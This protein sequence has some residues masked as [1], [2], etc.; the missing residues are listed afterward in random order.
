[1]EAFYDFMPEKFTREST[2]ERMERMSMAKVMEAHN[3]EEQGVELFASGDVNDRCRRASTD[4]PAAG[5]AGERGSTLDNFQHVR[6]ITSTVRGTRSRSDS[7]SDDSWK[8]GGGGGEGGAFGMSMSSL[9]GGSSGSQ[10]RSDS[11]DEQKDAS[12]K[13]S[14]GS[15]VSRKLKKGAEMGTGA[16]TG[17]S[18]GK[19]SFTPSAGTPSGGLRLSPGEMRRPSLRGVVKRSS[20]PGE[21][22]NKVAGGLVAGGDN[23]IGLESNPVVRASKFPSRRRLSSYKSSSIPSIKQ[24]SP[25]ISLSTADIVARDSGAHPRGHRSSALGIVIDEGEG[26]ERASRGYLGELAPA[27]SESN[28][29][30]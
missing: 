7:D 11:S 17:S 27:T 9:G 1:L 30:M 4:E 29:T 12:L 2:F 28:D 18:P 24:Q 22:G 14:V 16:G 19:L 21:S 26:D 20:P 13:Y 8:R 15:D 5:G 3:Q 10:R 6:K 23:T 25:G